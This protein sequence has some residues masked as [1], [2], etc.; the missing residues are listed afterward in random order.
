MN[1]TERLIQLCKSVVEEDG[2]VF[3]VFCGG[4]NC[5]DCPLANINRKDKKCCSYD[6]EATL[7]VAKNF[8]AEIGKNFLIEVDALEQEE[9]ESEKSYPFDEIVLMN[10]KGGIERGTKFKSDY[11]AIEILPNR[12]LKISSLKEERNLMITPS[13]MFI[14][15]KPYLTADNFNLEEEFQILGYEGVFKKIEV[16]GQIKVARRFDDGKVSVYGNDFLDGEDH[17]VRVNN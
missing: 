7:E 3:E 5:N 15:E 10:F 8:L 16:Y 6:R 4:I 11:N 17:L 12:T 2:D 13:E 1:K 14:M 9:Q